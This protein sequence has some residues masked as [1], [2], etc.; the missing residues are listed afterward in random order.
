MISNRDIVIIGQQPW[1]TKI[2]SNCKN[3]AEEF[4][5]H[6]RVLYVNTPLDRKTSLTRSGEEEVQF[7]K[8]VIKG[9]EEPLSKINDNMWNFTPRFMSESINWI[10]FKPLYSAINRHN[11]KRFAREIDYAC[12]KLNFKDIILFNDSLMFM[13][14][15]L[16]EYLNPS[17]Y[18]YYIRDNLITQPY[19]RKHA[20]KL[21]PQLM[22][23]A[24]LVVSNSDYLANYARK[25]NPKSFMVGQGCDVSHF[26]DD[27]GKMPVAG[28]LLNID[29][30]IIGY[31][32]FLTGIRLDIEVLE[33]IARSRPDWSLVLVGPE[34]EAFKNSELHK[35][36]NVHFLGSKPVEMLPNYIKG[37]DV[38]I[39]PQLVNELT[40]G[41][42]PRKID[43]YLAMGKPVVATPTEAMNYFADY[44]Y[45]AP[46]REAY[47]DKIE[48]ALKEDDNAKQSKRKQFARSH[49]WENNVKAIYEHIKNYFTA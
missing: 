7:R 46:T 44:T 48:M 41:N 27:E 25:Y 40:I 8:K 37:F 38:C 45:L 9:I 30:P 43:E 14:F 10:S 13:G 35:M 39:N 42:Y 49:T 1:D 47:V 2:G 24:D 12:K 34:D 11:N 36:S 29:K 26:N 33:H 6:N 22:R 31:V 32:G 20:L 23:K 18:I 3:I 19:F 28:D 17:I 16:K 21:E 15:Y 4:S 5:V